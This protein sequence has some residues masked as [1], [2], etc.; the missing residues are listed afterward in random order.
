VISCSTRSGNS[1]VKVFS[2]EKKVTSN[3][4]KTQIDSGLVGNV[5]N[6]TEDHL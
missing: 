5:L 1:R 3:Q 2:H 6:Q 4:K